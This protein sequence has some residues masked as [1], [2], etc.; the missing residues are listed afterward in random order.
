MPDSQIWQNTASGMNLELVGQVGGPTQAVA[1][2]G[3]YAYVG[4]GMRMVV[5]DVSNPSE[6]KQV[7][8]TAVF[9]D[10]VTGVA[11]NDT[12][13]C[14]TA[15]S[16]GFYI[17]DIT[18]PG[19]PSV[20]GFYDSPGFSENV[21]IEGK[22]AYVADGWE[23]LVVIDISNSSNPQEA[24][25]LSTVGY[26]FDVTVANHIAY[27]AAAGVGLKVVDVQYP[28]GPIE[29]GEYDTS[30]YAFGIALSDGIVYIAD[31]WEGVQIIDVSNP[32]QP[33][34]VGESETPGWAYGVDVSGNTIFVADAFR[35]V[36][37]ID[38][39][40]PS[41]PSEVGAFEVD[42]HAGRVTVSGDY[43]YVA[44]R[45]NGLRIIDISI[46]SNPIKLG[47]YSPLGFADAVAVAG[48]YAYIAGGAYG[49]RT[50]DIS[51]PTQPRE[52]GQYDT[53]AY[54]TS[55][56]VIGSYAYVA[57]MPGQEGDG[58]HIVDISDPANPTRAGFYHRQGV[59]AYR[60][61]AVSGGIAYLANE[62]GLELVDISNPHN[63]F[64]SG[65]IELWDSSG[66][67]STCGVDVNGNL[68]YV[69]IEQAGLKIINVVDP[70]NPTLIG[71]FS[72]DENFSRDV[73]VVGNRAY[74]AD[75][76][77][78]ILDVSNP[79][80]P[81]EMGYFDTP[82]ITEGVAVE[83]G[84]AYLAIGSSGIFAV[85]VSDPSNV[86]LIAEYNSRGFSYTLIKENDLFFIAD[87]NAGLIILR[88]LPSGYLIEQGFARSNKQLIS[89]PNISI[90]Q[91]PKGFSPTVRNKQ[92]RNLLSKSKSALM[93]KYS[94]VSNIL[95]VTTTADGGQGSLRWCIENA[96]S[97]DTISFDISIFPPDNSA[98]IFLSSQLP[99]INQGN[100][101]I[102]G[103]NAGMIINGERISGNSNGLWI[104]SDGN[105]VKGLQI[106]RF[107]QHGI[108][109]IGSNNVIGG[110]RLEG[111][112]PVGQGNVVSGNGLNGIDIWG[113][114]NV[115]VGNLIGTDATGYSAFGNAQ[116]GVFVNGKNN[117]IGGDESWERNISSGNGWHGVSL[118]S[119]RTSGN[120]VIGNYLGTDIDGSSDLG[121]H[122]HGVGI[123]L[124]AFSNFVKGNLLSGNGRAGACVSDWGSSYN[125]IVGNIIGLDASGTYAIGNDW[126]GVFVGFMGA[127]FNRIGGTFP[128]EKNIISGN[129][130][131][132]TAGIDLSGPAAV[133]VYVL[134]NLIGLDPTGSRPVPN[135]IG[136]RI[137]GGSEHNF[138]G[139][140]TEEER[141]VI[142]G[143]NNT[144]IELGEHN[145][146]GG[147]Y[148]GASADGT[149]YINNDF[150]GINISRRAFHNA[151]CNNLITGEAGMYLNGSEN[152][153]KGNTI[154]QNNY[155]L[156][157]N[158]DFNLIFYNKFQYN[159]TQAEDSGDNDWDKDGAGNYWSDYTGSD[160]DGNG[161]G[162]TP[163][164]IPLNGTDH[165]PLMSD[166]NKLTVHVNPPGSGNVTIIPNKSSYQYGENVR[167]EANPAGDS[168]FI[169]WSGGCP[170]GQEKD[171][172]LT[173][174]MNSDKTI[175]ANFIQQ[176]TLTISAGA[177][178]KTDPSPGIYTHDAGT[179]V[180][181]K[182]IPDSGYTFSSWSGDASGTT[183]PITV[184]MNS[185]KSITANFT[186]V[187]TSKDEKGRGGCF[188]ATACYGTPMAEEVETLSAFRDQYLVKNPIGR[189]LV[190]F[191]Y[192]YSPNVA[193]FIQ[194]KEDIKTVIRE[195]LKPFILIIS[196]IVK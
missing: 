67:Y 130:G 120:S 79:A 170:S 127:S 122:G 115:V 137:G 182:A 132:Y 119:K 61:M 190:N 53:K 22:Y 163:Y 126:C 134:G 131:N 99:V 89:P 49:L 133:D 4:I 135:D 76:G 58:L 85:D 116:H 2:K 81:V 192:K 123:E 106:I 95:V 187:T 57:T 159:Q 59:G 112:G 158:G 37:V 52:L 121:N 8:E 184:T 43:A 17:V 156:S 180:T 139:G 41:F 62:M 64:L 51:N 178:G 74:L 70:T 110:S 160:P 44:D 72:C 150:V 18:N 13:A 15:G 171:N 38:V 105:T 114:N 155:G 147:N 179:S 21:F 31:G 151:I 183:N 69:A 145:Y 144:G 128:Q 6:I 71:V 129:V 177:G 196:M 54:A 77:L 30:G 100:I 73:T 92:L 32:Y 55:V 164:S 23:G 102:D 83:G 47:L 161:I 25:Y 108:G 40:S 94:N 20:I 7:G 140:I 149:S 16:A 191:Y 1:V 103:S 101:I 29:I 148:I 168:P 169:F 104:V 185:D 5:L 162:D 75:R 9:D 173:I 195:L 118:L 125:T 27:I 176:Y 88:M 35:G 65:F 19:Q 39:S 107:P 50:I 66:P 186:Q 188:I 193:Y 82:D 142:S 143:N 86:N 153:I 96:Q 56:S 136:I 60:D 26:A 175:T 45:N 46:I 154:S 63:P 138:I 181:I 167:L 3:D 98:T 157:A 93:N 42:G 84:I 87:G 91:I 10:F 28:T 97:G 11:V 165:Y 14:V 172:P 24:G 146:I 117:I 34:S 12:V 166:S 141:N 109:I 33:I 174:T 124:A 78:R 111:T 80:A 36:R 48:N 194:D 68:A 113:D 90:N 152:V 189:N